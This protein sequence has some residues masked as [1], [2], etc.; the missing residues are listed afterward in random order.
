MKMIR[1][2]AR[3]AGSLRSLAKEWGLSVSYLSQVL[4][5]KKLPGKKILDR[6]GLDVPEVYQLK[7]PAEK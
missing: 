3:R 7:V 1:M 4:N 6:L 2:R 5:G